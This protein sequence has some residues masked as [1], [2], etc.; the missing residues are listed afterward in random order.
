MSSE[1]TLAAA[2][3]VLTDRRLEVAAEITRAKS[4]LEDLARRFHDLQ[5]GIN[6]IREA[7]QEVKSSSRR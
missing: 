3:A 2:C 7:L 6:A 1:E 4:G 5:V